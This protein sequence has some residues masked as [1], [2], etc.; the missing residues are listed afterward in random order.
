MFSKDFDLDIDSHLSAHDR[1]VSRM[2]QRMLGEGSL[3]CNFAWR[4]HLSDNGKLLVKEFLGGGVKAGIARYCKFFLS[5]L[6]LKL[7]PNLSTLILFSLS[8]HV[9]LH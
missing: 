8:F 2:V 9:N 1:G 3:F 5:N 4:F 6:T 7:K